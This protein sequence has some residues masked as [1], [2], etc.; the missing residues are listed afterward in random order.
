MCWS[1]EVSWITLVVGTILNIFLISCVKNTTVRVVAILWQ[2]VLLMQFFEALIWR[3]NRTGDT[4]LCVWASK[5]A[6]YANVLQPVIVAVLL[7]CLCGGG[8]STQNKIVAILL[9]CAYVAWLVSNSVSMNK[10]RCVTTSEGCGHLDLVWWKEF[11]LGA[12]PYLILLGAVIFLLLRPL[13][14]ASL[15]AAYIFGSLII[16]SVFYKC[17]I[18][19]MWCWFAAFAPL[20]TLYISGTA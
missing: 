14:F 19:S 3:A 9:V 11:S 4:K 10:D 18:A 13:K 20:Y 15:I 2:W 17:G 5:G 8:V 12:L 1:E 7:L 16:S 6:L